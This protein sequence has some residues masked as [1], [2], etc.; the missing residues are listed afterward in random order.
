MFTLNSQ[1]KKSQARQAVIHTSHGE[2]QTPFFM[3]IATKAAVK[4]LSITDIE[5]LMP[6]ILLSNTYHL[7]LRPNMDIME[8]AGGLHNFM[9]WNGPILTDSGGYQV[10]SLSSMRKL[11]EK[12]VT[13]QSHIDGS[14][15]ELTPERAIQIQ[16]TIGSDIMMCLDECT[17]YPCDYTYAKDSLGLTTRWAKRCKEYKENN[18]DYKS[19]SSQKLF[20]IVQGST[21]KDLRLESARQLID[22][23]FDG[24]AIGGL[25]VGEPREKTFDVLSELVPVLPEDKPRYLMGV[26]YP[27]EIVNAVRLGVDMFDCVIPTREGRHGR[28]FQFKD[29]NNIDFSS[30]DFYYTETI[31]NAKFKEDFSPVN[32]DSEIPELQQYTKSYVHHLFRTGETLGSRIATLQNVDFYLTLMRE[33]QKQ[34]KD[35]KF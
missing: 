29:R 30:D 2:I 32:K 25:A 24:Y 22:L 9:K 31:K 8:K 3:T 23:D 26:G 10:F 35:G 12:G 33:L 27:E 1:S 17:P 19:N 20:G 15:H 13:F 18:N 16:Q 5:N 7:M 21:Y 14:A 34:I 4:T 28:L 6:P 11:S